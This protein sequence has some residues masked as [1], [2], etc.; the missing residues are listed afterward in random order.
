MKKANEKWAAKMKVLM[1]RAWGLFRKGLVSFSL[2]LRL[3]WAL[4]KGQ[5]SEWDLQKKLKKAGL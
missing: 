2:S 5:I 4:E 1:N 3:S